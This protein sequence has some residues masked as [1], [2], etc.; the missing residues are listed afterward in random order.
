MAEFGT[1]DAACSHSSYTV[2]YTENAGAQATHEE[3][4]L[5]ATTNGL[6]DYRNCQ[7][8]ERLYG[9]AQLGSADLD[10]CLKPAH[11]A[12]DQSSAR[13]GE[14]ND[15]SG[16]YAKGYRVTDYLAS[17]RIFTARGL[18]IS[19]PVRAIVLAQ[20][21]HASVNGR[22]CTREGTTW[23]H[24]IVALSCTLV[25]M[26]RTQR[27]CRHILDVQCVDGEHICRVTCIQ[28]IWYIVWSLATA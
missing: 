12:R 10:V 11:R 26:A 22:A 17:F 1:R 24:C 6:S 18:K 3:Y 21:A 2:P 25:H 14:C 13:A 5:I 23:F 19:R 15:E 8:R 28:R 27:S 7:G 4:A 9:V 20:W 16:E